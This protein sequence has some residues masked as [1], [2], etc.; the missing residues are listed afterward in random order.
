MIY[1]LTDFNI[2][3][4][5]CTYNLF[6]EVVSFP[7]KAMVIFHSY[8]SS[9]VSLMIYISG[10]LQLVLCQVSNEHTEVSWTGGTPKSS[11]LR[12][13]STINPPFRGTPICGNP[14]HHLELSRRNARVYST[15][16]LFGRL[17]NRCFLGSKAEHG[18]S[19]R[20]LPA[21][22]LGSDHPSTYWIWFLLCEQ[23]NKVI[24]PLHST[25]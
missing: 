8:G 23:R 25:Y 6:V 3:L 9:P 15:A 16:E 13:C 11:I 1:T 4:I 5:A 10:N 20:C 2:F 22:S 24:S 18:R 17:R 12:G 14:Q 21:A 7:S 19:C